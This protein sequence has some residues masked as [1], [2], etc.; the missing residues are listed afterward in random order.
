MALMRARAFNDGK[1]R[2]SSAFAVSNILRKSTPCETAFVRSSC[3]YYCKAK[4]AVKF[5]NTIAFYWSAGT[6]VRCSDFD[7]HIGVS[8]RETRHLSSWLHPSRLD[9][10]KPVMIVR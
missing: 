8:R 6:G 10:V 5:V 1:A 9:R 2:Y 4:F 3:Q 7:T